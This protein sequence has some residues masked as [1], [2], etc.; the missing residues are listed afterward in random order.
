MSRVAGEKIAA[1]VGPGVDVSTFMWEV[2][3]VAELLDSSDATRGV[4]KITTEMLRPIVDRARS[5]LPRG[6][7]RTCVVSHLEWLMQETFERGPRDGLHVLR[8]ASLEVARYVYRAEIAVRA[9]KS[10]YEEQYQLAL[11]RNQAISA[12][13]PIA[14]RCLVRSPDD[15]MEM[16]ASACRMISLVDTDGVHVVLNAAIVLRPFLSELEEVTQIVMETLRVKERGSPS[17]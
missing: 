14:S 11:A 5:M 9:H 17:A 2:R 4:V 1:L 16:V 7:S 6:V 15:A 13:E 3:D 8:I 10:S 12:L